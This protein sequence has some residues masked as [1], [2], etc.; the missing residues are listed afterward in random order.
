M[1]CRDYSEADDIRELRKNLDARTAELCF[2]RKW[3]VKAVDE[4]KLAREDLPTYKILV[5]QH[6]K[7]REEDRT[8]YIQQLGKKKAE[9]TSV[10]VSLLSINEEVPTSLHDKIDAV[11]NKINEILEL[12]VEKFLA[13]H[14]DF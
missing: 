11:T 14:P 4:K 12:P 7:H 13:Y 1:P 9:Y 5:G 2:V 10:A 3:V 6:A 8:Q